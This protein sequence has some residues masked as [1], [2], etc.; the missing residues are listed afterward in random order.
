MRGG[1]RGTLALG[2]DVGGNLIHN[3]KTLLCSNSEIGMYI[4]SM[5]LL[6]HSVG[7]REQATSKDMQ[8]EE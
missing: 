1:G 2:E 7:S 3:L 5:K 6:I 4:K 8:M